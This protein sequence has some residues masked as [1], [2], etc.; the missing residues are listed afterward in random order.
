M[1]WLDKA[2]DGL[3]ARGA[4]SK[5]WRGFD[6]L[7]V[8][9]MKHSSWPRSIKKYKNPRS[10]GNQLR[11]LDKGAG[12]DFWVGK[13][14]ALLPVLGE[15]TG[16]GNAAV[17]EEI[18]LLLAQRDER[19]HEWR[20]AAFPALRP[21]DLANESL[22]P[23]VPGELL[24]GDGHGLWFR[25]GPRRAWWRTRPGS[26]RAAVAMRLQAQHG[27][28]YIDASDWDDMVGQLPSRG[29]AFVILRSMEGGGEL[30]KDPFP[31]E[32]E[33]VIAAPFEP[34]PGIDHIP[35]DE[36]HGVL[37]DWERRYGE[38]PH[39]RR[40]EAS[41]SEAGIRWN[42]I[43][44]PP[45]KDWIED[46]IH[47]TGAR[48]QVGGGFNTAHAKALI[49]RLD[50]DRMFQTPGEVMDLFALLDE[51]GLEFLESDRDDGSDFDR[52]ARWFLRSRHRG[53]GDRFAADR[54]LL[55]H[56]G[57][58][59]LVALEK[60]RLRRDLP[61]EMTREG[62]EQLVPEEYHGEGSREEIAELLRTG[63]EADRQ[64][65]L[66]LLD[67][68]AATII[69][70][71]IR[72]HVLQADGRE[73]LSLHPLWM[74]GFIEAV[75]FEELMEGPVTDVGSALLRRHHP[76]AA[77]D[78]LI[79]QATE[80][81]WETIERTVEEF[82]PSQPE[83]VAA[84]EGAFRAVG[85]AV[86]ADVE[87]DETL[88]IK[89]WNL[90]MACAVRPY[91]NNPPVQRTLWH[92]GEGKG[93]YSQ[94]GFHLA[95]L[96]ISERIGDRVSSGSTAH[97]PW[98]AETVHPDLPLTLL[99]IA[100][101]FTRS[102]DWLCDR[103]LP[104]VFAIGTRLM[105]AVG[106]VPQ[107][108]QSHELNPLQHPAALVR[109]Y[110]GEELGEPYREKGLHKISELRFPMV[111][112]E[113]EC[114]RAGID[115]D[116]VL[117][118]CWEQ[119]KERQDLRGIPPL[120][121]IT[122]NKRHA[123]TERLWRLLDATAATDPICEYMLHNRVVWP[124]LDEAKWE[125]LFKFLMDSASP[126]Q[127]HLKLWYEAPEELCLRYLNDPRIQDSTVEVREILWDRMPESILSL[128]DSIVTTTPGVDQR[129]WVL[130]SNLM[131]A[132][133]ASQLDRLLD[134]VEQWL[135]M[136][137]LP[138]PITIRL[139]MRMEDLIAHRSPVWR[140]AYTLLG[141]LRP[142]EVG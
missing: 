84:L 88:L 130:M 67:R 29:R 71:L 10:L 100:S 51:V 118:W 126:M 61:R 134:H 128:L 141:Q 9:M 106:E 36:R 81:H 123:D 4:G 30:H 133:P 93:I 60:E 80:G 131:H 35:P 49:D 75:A 122:N 117:E 87:V 111:A 116:K 124:F 17:D 98:S 109:C 135:V 79:V 31:T 104:A 57:R 34:G 121:W 86:L 63:D 11:N 82:D 112:L 56:H 5:I 44:T 108:P 115:V 125:R 90:Q 140:R 113:Q 85:L 7:A 89:L 21:L 77:L 33:L 37:E 18:D 101:E 65:A 66:R 54:E 137:N 91:F 41:S 127:N 3:E 22:F 28:R 43:H 1:G 97:R 119:W 105:D 96:A 16:W 129:V 24:T 76:E 103:W 58:D 47:W 107:Y 53:A 142:I 62:W 132:T 38:R 110:Q 139:G 102:E 120:L 12:L 48:V 92:V 55:Q 8:N 50:M 14:R 26:G 74:Q 59:L 78:E 2:I 68:S 73:R 136:G 94:Y 25:N 42:S 19:A 32:L 83:A 13:G 72:C 70:V 64:E 99:G 138:A 6:A 23:G 27:W 46:L 40:P 69:A 45:P 20:F 15:V 52:L 95:A 114:Q 39:L